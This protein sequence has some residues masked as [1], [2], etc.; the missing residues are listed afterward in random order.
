MRKRSMRV[1]QISKS[2]K[3]P[4]TSLVDGGSTPK[5]SKSGL[6]AEG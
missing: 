3:F 1:L 6:T 4:I 2:S 5:G